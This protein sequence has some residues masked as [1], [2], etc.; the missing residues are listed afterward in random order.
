MIDEGFEP[1]FPPEV[2]RQLAALKTGTALSRRTRRAK[3]NE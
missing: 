1:D 2:G 3:W